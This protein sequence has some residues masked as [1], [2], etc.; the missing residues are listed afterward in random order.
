MK[1]QN[2]FLIA[3]FSLI[4][5]LPSL[6]QIFHFSP[7]K[8]I[9]EKRISS[10]KPELPSSLADL[11]NYPSRFE[12]F[13]NDNYGFRKTLISL[14]SQMMDKTFDESPDS[15]AVVGSE[16]WFFFDNCN[17]LVDAEGK[18][19]LSD[20]SIEVGVESF[21]KNWHE[22]R[23]KNVDYLVI[24]A[25]DKSS[26]Y[27]EFLPSYIKPTIGNHRIDK[28][29]AALKKRYPDFPLLDLRPIL[30]A[31]KKS[32]TI[33]HQTDT[34]WNRRGAYYAYV[35]IMKKFGMNFHPRR[36]F[37]NKEN[38]TTRGDISDIMGIDA[39]NKN[40]D[41]APKFTPT[42][43]LGNPSEAE[44]KEFHRAQIYEN[45]N[46]NLPHVFVY[47]DSFFGDLFDL[48]GEHFSFIFSANESP[49]NL[50]YE[51]IRRYRPNVVIHEFW[52]GRIEVILKRCK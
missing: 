31:A 27:P 21:A 37:A 2:I 34:H 41:L 51:A 35:E 47:N 5:L 14:H 25:A 22:L 16:G 19:N 10:A 49:C 3:V 50:D 23:A 36:D 32:E 33:Y 12:K 15:R 42:V 44:K 45:K 39:R 9:F 38:E 17:S 24:I 7:V 40:L 52:E 20:E 4:L 6:D 26:I 30:L 18:A 13:F 46:K 1:L 28:F 48:V 43:R 29:I 11:K 8:E